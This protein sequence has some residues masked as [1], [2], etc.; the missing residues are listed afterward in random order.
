MT[1]ETQTQTRIIGGIARPPTGHSPETDSIYE[2][3]LKK[4]K[5]IKR[6][7]SRIQPRQQR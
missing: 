7:N 4:A 2:A 5:Q 6:A 1:K 3:A